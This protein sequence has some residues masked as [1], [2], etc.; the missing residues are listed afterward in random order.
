MV[1]RAALP[2]QAFARACCRP[3]RL[4]TAALAS[5]RDA[6]ASSRE[7]GIDRCGGAA[8]TGCH[9][10]LAALC[11]KLQGVAN[12]PQSG[13]HSRFICHLTHRLC[14]AAQQR[15]PDTRRAAPPQALALGPVGGVT[16]SSPASPP[17][18]L[19]LSDAFEDY[20]DN[21]PARWVGR[22]VQAGL[23]GLSR[24]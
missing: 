11:R 21:P 3:A 13:Y 6:G 10:A 2:P 24:A 9:H 22:R 7:G 4:Q 17:L 23:I 15:R 18:D 12:C 14:R 19:E 8:Q 16:L 1:G 5:R 20:G